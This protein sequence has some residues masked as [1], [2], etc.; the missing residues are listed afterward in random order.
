MSEVNDLRDAIRIAID[1]R[2]Q[3][4]HHPFKTEQEWSHI[5]DIMMHARQY[6][7][8]RLFYATRPHTQG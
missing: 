1:L 2:W 4:A 5:D 7:E 8:S 6:L 3:I